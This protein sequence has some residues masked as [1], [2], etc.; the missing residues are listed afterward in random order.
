MNFLSGWKTYGASAASFVVIGLTGVGV[1]PPEIAV[2]ILGLIGAA[3]PAF[4]RDAITT[5]TKKAAQQLA[6][7]QPPA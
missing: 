3:V 5:E 6:N 7:P 2:Y 1:I 4:L